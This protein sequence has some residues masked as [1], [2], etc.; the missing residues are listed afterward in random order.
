MPRP[1]RDGTAARQLPNRRKLSDAFI[2][3]VQPDPDRV[4]IFW[5]VVQRGLALAVQPSGHLAWKCIYAVRG[6][7][8]RWFHIGNARSIPLPDARKLASRITVEVA[9]GKDPHADRIA[10]RGRG[11]FADVASRYVKECASK[12]NKSWRQGDALVTRYLLPRWAKLDVGDIRR[13]DVRSTIA[14]ITKPVLAN[15]VLASAS[16][17]FNWA[18]RQDIIAANPCS[19]IERNNTT[20]RERILGDSE[21]TVFWPHLTA[22][23][24]MILLTGQRPGEVAH[25]HPAHVADGWWTMPGAPDP[26]TGWPGT[27]NAQSHRVWLSEPVHE[28]LPDVLGTPGE[29]RPAAGGH[30]QH[31]HQVRYQREGDAA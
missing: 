21:I 13:A 25:L 24:R 1:R 5:D 29:Y 8:S 4:I 18:V 20:S 28:L 7:G 2:K 17:V 10:L 11:S 14:A 15:Q 26:K 27:K 16:A 12:K 6:R 19:G 30:A 31:L 9:G 23:L 3:T 22:P